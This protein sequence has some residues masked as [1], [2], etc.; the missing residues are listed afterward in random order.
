MDPRDKAKTAFICHR[1]SF[2]FTTMPMG[3][4]NAGSTFQRLMDLVMSGLAFE[5]CLVYLDDIIVFSRTVE[6]HLER[7]EA[8]LQRLIATNLK[9]KP[10][11]CM[12]LQKRV[13][14]LGHLISESGIETDPKKTEGIDNWETP[15]SLKDVRSFLGLCS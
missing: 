4:V 8:V 12:L 2:Q 6:D 10:S 15:R 5:Q 3:L 7:L 13:K 9:L 14:F 11:K 1:G